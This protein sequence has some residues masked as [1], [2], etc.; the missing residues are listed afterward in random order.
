[1]KPYLN[2]TLSDN[3]PTHLQVGDPAPDFT[4]LTQSGESV[5]L[6]DYRGKKLVLFFYPRDNTPGCTL[7]VCNLRDNYTELVEAGYALLGVSPDSAR[8]HQNFIKKFGLP[9]PLIAD[10][11]KEILQAYGVWGQKKFMGRT[12]TGVLRTTFI[13]DEQ[14]RIEQIIDKVD[15]RHHASQIL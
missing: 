1:M 11:E 6:E 7:E 4:G 8:K 2:T 15:T 13:I 3:M 14:G 10:T 12:F 5:S 9:F